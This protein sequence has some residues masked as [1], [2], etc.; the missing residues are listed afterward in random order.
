MSNYEAIIPGLLSVGVLGVVLLCCFKLYDLF[1]A[2]GRK[3]KA[4][5]ASKRAEG[6]RSDLLS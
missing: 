2:L 3:L 4:R 5:H 1:A 6:A